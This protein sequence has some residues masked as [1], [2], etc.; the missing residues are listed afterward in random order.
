MKKQIIISIFILALAACVNFQRV[1]NVENSVPNK[2]MVSE[3]IIQKIPVKSKI[4]LH[5]L[6]RS[7]VIAL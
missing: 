5:E 6:E 1:N 2:M 3:S 7:G 4:I